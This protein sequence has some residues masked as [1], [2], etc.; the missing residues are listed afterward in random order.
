MAMTRDEAIRADNERQVRR[1]RSLESC[2]VNVRAFFK[3][4]QNEFEREAYV[5]NLA[6]LHSFE[7]W[8][9]EP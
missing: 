9:L 7:W 5:Q 2:R 6:R 8:E 3:R 1:L 4:E